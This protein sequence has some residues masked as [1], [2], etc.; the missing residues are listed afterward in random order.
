[1]DPL[2]GLYFLGPDLLG[3]SGHNGLLQIRDQVPGFLEAHR[4]SDQGIPNALFFPIFGGQER[5]GGLG[6]GK[7]GTFHPGKDRKST[8]LNSSHVKNSYAVFCLKKKNK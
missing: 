1:M 2:A 3:P 5:M 8:R 6:G 4:K 7:Y